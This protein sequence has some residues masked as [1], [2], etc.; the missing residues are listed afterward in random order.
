MQLRI[1]ITRPLWPGGRGRTMAQPGLRAGRAR[2]RRLSAA[3]IFFLVISAANPL[4]SVVGAAP[5]GIV[6]GNG[7]GL[8]AAYVV[9]T[10]LLLCFAV[11]YAAISRRVVNTGAYYSYIAQGV[12]RPPAIGAAML[13]IVAYAINV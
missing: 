8:P 2:Q 3:W 6:N 1:V 12:G 5:L 7:A 10:L 11:G 9:V 4:T 13:A